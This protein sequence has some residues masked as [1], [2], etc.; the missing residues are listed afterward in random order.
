MGLRRLSNFAIALCVWLVLT[1]STALAHHVMGGKLP[2]SLPDGLLS[3]L[4][5]PIIGV[6][7][8][9]AVIAVGLLAAAHRLG[10][11]LIVGYVLAQVAGAAAH[12][13][14]TSVPAAEILVGLSVVALGALL[15]LHRALPPA[16]ILAAFGLA[17]L[18]HGYA[19]AESIVGAEPTPLYAYFAGFAAIQAIVALV[20]LAIVRN[21]PR[22][23]W[24]QHANVRLIGAGIVGLGIGAVMTQLV[25]AG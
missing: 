4:G 25:A 15:L 1:G 22:P 21:L 10:P 17:G 18:F 9:A 5:H 19:L 24:E 2:A 20:A 8:L 11:L 3:G 6:D 16:A 13:Q 14:G 23:V 7:H 12:V